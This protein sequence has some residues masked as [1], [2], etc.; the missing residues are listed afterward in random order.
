MWALL[1]TAALATYPEPDTIVFD[2]IE[3]NQYNAIAYRFIEDAP[4]QTILWRRGH[5][6]HW[7]GGRADLSRDGEGCYGYI[8][9][10]FVRGLQYKDTWS[11]CDIEIEDRWLN[12]DGCTTRYRRRPS[13]W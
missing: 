11:W 5:V 6:V 9:G 2:A 1:L 7:T 8:D 10:R 3:H 13:E 4:V 12:G